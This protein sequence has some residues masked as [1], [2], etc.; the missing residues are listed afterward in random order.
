MENVKEKGQ[1]E[2][3]DKWCWTGWWWKAI[4]S[5]KKKPNKER[6]GDIRTNHSTII[7]CPVSQKIL[8]LCVPTAVTCPQDIVYK[9][10]LF[11]TGTKSSVTYLFSHKW[12]YS[13]ILI[14]E[15]RFPAIKIELLLLIAL[16]EIIFASIARFCFSI[17]NLL[18]H[19]F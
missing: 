1:E 16:H 14:F 10:Y 19:P 7:I 8:Y 2:D 4:G 12:S 5:W 9:F 3:Q 11:T 6:S 13:F 18:F 15:I 17:Y